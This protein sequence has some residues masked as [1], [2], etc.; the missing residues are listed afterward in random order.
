M[1]GVGALALV[2]T[3]W[4]GAPHFSGPWG[5][6][7][8]I[9]VPWVAGLIGESALLGIAAHALAGRPSRPFKMILRALRRFPVIAAVILLR[10][11]AVAG[12]LGLGLVAADHAGEYAS[13]LLL[14]AGIIAL[15]VSSAFSQATAV[16][17]SQRGGPLRALAVSTELTRDLRMT[18]LKAK[19]K[20]ALLLLLLGVAVSRL[21]EISPLVERFGDGAIEVLW[22]STGALL[23][24]V[25]YL[26]CT[27]RVER[28]RIE[29]VARG[30][31]EAID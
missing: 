29:T 26:V 1:L 9:G 21:G 6:V 23:T 10:V 25:S 16:A 31:S 20:L 13:L 4:L 30:I 28:A 3:W 8:G 19:A 22:F 15:G 27:A 24:S 18:V 11:L 7:E 14:A 2:P 5:L 17:F 12:I